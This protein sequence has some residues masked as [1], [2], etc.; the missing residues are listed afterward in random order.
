[1]KYDVF[2]SYRRDGGA[3]TARLL[4]DRLTEMGYKVF[5]DMESLRSGYFNTALYSVIDQCKDVIVV[6]SPNALDHCVYEG[7]WVRR[8]V[9][10]ALFRKKNVIPVF[11]Q[12]FQFP[13]TLP[14]SIDG[15]RYCNGI[16]ASEAFFDAFLDKLKDFL[17]SKPS[18]FQSLRQSRLL[19]RMIPVILAVILVLA[20]FLVVSAYLR[21]LQNIYPR[22]QQ[23][24]T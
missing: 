13:Y 6:L 14:P 15:L 17:K 9:E 7:D 2:I 20:G 19:K 22:T 11:L 18:F 4:R 8:E 12:G 10:H 23:D 24:K 5:F 21:S 1:M 16:G 3:A